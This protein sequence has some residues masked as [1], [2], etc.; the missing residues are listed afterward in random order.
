LTIKEHLFCIEV[1]QPENAPGLVV[2]EI[3][4]ENDVVVVI[5]PSLDY[6]VKLIHVKLV[7]LE[8]IKQDLDSVFNFLV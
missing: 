1:V 6:E 8:P 2:D 4:P 3:I 5:E 7:G